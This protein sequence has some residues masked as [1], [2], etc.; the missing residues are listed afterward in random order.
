M[1]TKIRTS[2]PR[3]QAGTITRA[4]LPSPT[5][6]PVVLVTASAGFGKSQLMARWYKE[7]SSDFRVAY[8]LCSRL[9]ET[10]ST[11][12]E[13]LYASLQVEERFSPDSPWQ[14]QADTLLEILFESEPTLLILDDT[15]HLE[16]DTS[17][18]DDCSLLLS[19][20]LDY[21]APNCHWVF[22]GRSRPQLADLELKLM[23]GEF[24]EVNAQSLTLQ[25]SDLEE[26]RPGHGSKLFSLT[27]GWPMATALLLRS[28]PA[29]WEK[30]REKLSQG[31][32]ELALSQINEEAR[33]AVAVLGLLGNATREELESERLWEILEPLAQN[34]T[35]VHKSDD[36]KLAVHPLFSEQYREQASPSQMETAVA[37]LRKS[38]RFWEALELVKDP[39]TLAQLLKES[40]ESLLSAGRSKLLAKLLARA[41]RDPELAILE[42]RMHWYIGDPA[43]A[44]E[45]FQQAAKEAAHAHLISR[46]WRA[47]GKL[48]IDAVC[49]REAVPYLKKAYRALSS[50]DKEKKAQVLHLLAENAVNLGQAKQAIRYRKLARNWDERQNEDLALTA[51]MLLRAGKLAEARGTV[52]VAIDQGLADQLK[53]HRDPRL[54]LSY[55][56]CLQGRAEQAQELAQEVLEQAQES[57]DR[58]TQSV[59]LTRLAHAHL[60]KERADAELGEQKAL[61]LYSE[62]DSLARTLGVERLRAECL[63]GQALHYTAQQNAPRAYEACREGVKIA[64]Q[65]G[66]AWL[67]AWLNFAQAVAALGGGHPSGPELIAAAQEDFKRCRD[68]FGFAL[69]EVWLRPEDGQ[70]TAVHLKEFPFLAQRLNLFGPPPDLISTADSAQPEHHPRQLQVFCLGTLSL[71]RDGE[72]VPNKAFKRKKA[73]ELFVLLLASPDTFF[74]RE[75]LAAQLWPDA[76]QKAALRDF[77]VALHALSDALEPQ[78]A[79]NTTAFCIERQEERY[80]LLSKKMDLDLTRFEALTVPQSENSEEWEKAV[81]LYRGPFC[82]DYPYLESL[83]SVRQRYDDL[84]LQTAQRLGEHY[85]EAE[86]PA[87]TTEL[88][89]KMLQRDATWEPAYRMLLRSQHALGHEHLLPRTFTRC[90]ETLEEE[91]GVEPSEE[92]FEVARELLGAQLQ[93]LL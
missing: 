58:R 38:Q 93:T 5:E 3:R 54:V 14:E 11:L 77:R 19:Y 31:L 79:K 87:A 84:Y 83:E 43:S 66:D 7:C 88:A 24:Q 71:I 68:R 9:G 65:S 72:A 60:L 18:A 35:L 61:A 28:E 91:L 55:I 76:S 15:H 64:R 16:S 51:R 48:Y 4:G 73:R 27:S 80:R 17:E 37:I 26:L 70:A 69:C 41:P 92:T 49:P 10:A 2:P 13:L 40:G 78:R 21:R 81:R 46:A 50:G 39:T 42:G 90:L 57:N 47:A 86:Q 8:A 89:Q 74:H 59:A 29:E 33:Q 56:C 75:E 30:Q 12:L 20:L 32:L 34:G 22:C 6:Y 63:M 36:D 67:S 25:V 62:A 45:C 82:E 53:G 85:L 44:L 23:T 1:L 52:Q